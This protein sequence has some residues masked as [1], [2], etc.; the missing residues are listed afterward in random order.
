MQDPAFRA[1]QRN[2]IYAPHVEPINRLVD[3]LASQGLG[4]VPRVAPVHGGVDAQVLLVLR[5]P[6]PAV[7][8]P[9]LEG[10]GFLCA[11]N[12]DPTAEHVCELLDRA[13]I[14]VNLTLPWNAY[15]WY[16]NRP[17]S[18]AELRTG[19]EPL[20]RLLGLLPR[21]QVVL[22]LGTHAQLSWNL[23]LQAH[24]GAGSDLRVLSSRHPGDRRSS[25]PPGSVR[26]GGRTR[27]S[28]S[29]RRLACCTTESGPTGQRHL[30]LNGPS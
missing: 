13:G 4:W 6:G 10:T 28:S 8:D 29:R 17:S 3:E 30:I 16:V 24:P 21:L 15:P 7:A 9:D 11:E 26:S 18:V 19:V 27:R 2:Q 25:A 14:D 1:D 12:N 20:R 22:L 23:L 5:D